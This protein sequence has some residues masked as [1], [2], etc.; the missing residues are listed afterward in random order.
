MSKLCVLLLTMVSCALAVDTTLADV[1]KS[2]QYRNLGPWRTGAWVTSLAVPETPA[3]AHRRTMFA[4]ARTGGVWR[5]ANNGTAWDPVTDSV[6]IASVG[7]VAVAPSDANVVWVGTGDNSLTR[8]AYWGDGVYKSTDGGA[9]WANMGL[10]DTEHIARIVIHPTNPDIVWVAALGHLGTPNLFASVDRGA[11][12]VPFQSNMGPAPVTD[13][14]VHP[15]EGDLVVGTYGRGI[16]VTNIVPLRGINHAVLSSDAALLPIRSFAERNEGSFGN[17]RLLGDRYPTTPNE[18]NAMTIAYYLKDMPPDSTPAAAAAPG[19][20]GGGGRGGFGGAP[21]VA[22]GG[23]GR[24]PYLTIADTSG[25]L[26]CTLIPPS[27][28][29][30]NQVTWSLNTYAPPA[31]DSDTAG[32]GGRGGR[33]GGAQS[34]PALPGDYTF[35]LHAGDKTYMQKAR[36]I[37]RAPADASRGRGIN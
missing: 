37:S 24:R 3:Q 2:F 30:V 34:P 35:T 18:P 15:R 26:V 10:R 17:Y 22:D 31:A 23:D 1:L 29:G 8:S 27:R 4:G 12:W 36:L 28:A 6:G 5:T 11:N 19:G 33:G 9:T 7:A 14:L 25:K 16:W 21:C 20:R 13:L 32:R